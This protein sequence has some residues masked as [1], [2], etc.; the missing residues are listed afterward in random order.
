MKI[1]LCI[2]IALMVATSVAAI[3][4]FRDNHDAKINNNSTSCIA[5][6]D[7][8]VLRERLK[9]KLQKRWVPNLEQALCSESAAI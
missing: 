1:I 8:S 7:R 3:A 4:G 6:K 2:I 5:F 9:E